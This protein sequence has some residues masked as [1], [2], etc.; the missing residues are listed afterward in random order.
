MRREEDS[1]E[2]YVKQIEWPMWNAL[3]R[4]RLELSDGMYHICNVTSKKI[5]V[6]ATTVIK[7]KA[8]IHKKGN[9]EKINTAEDKDE[10]IWARNKEDRKVRRNIRNC[11]NRRFQRAT[12]RCVNV[13]KN[14]R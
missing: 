8:Q 13:S 7:R 12:V 1:I 11:N 5:N 4:L 6:I 14:P 3:I 9:E 10:K 2:L